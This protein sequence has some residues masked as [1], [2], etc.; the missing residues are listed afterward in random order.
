MKKIQ[1]A[2]FILL[3]SKVFAQS[4][5]SITKIPDNLKENADAIVRFDNTEFIYN[6]L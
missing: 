3:T 6:K 5:L 2:I 4:D 1:I